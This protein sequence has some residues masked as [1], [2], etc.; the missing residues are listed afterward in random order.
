MKN[1]LQHAVFGRESEVLRQFSFAV[2]ISFPT[3]LPRFL[4]AAVVVNKQ[5]MDLRF[6]WQLDP[7]GRRY[8]V[9]SSISAQFS[10]NASSDNPAFL[11]FEIETF[12]LLIRIKIDNE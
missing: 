8:F 7:P 3:A 11:R 2:S 1:A 12:L 5:L 6:K 4:L 9:R 10:S